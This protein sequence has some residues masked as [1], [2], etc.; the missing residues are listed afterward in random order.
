MRK[1]TSLENNS[2]TTARASTAR[3]AM[4]R[5]LACLTDVQKGNFSVCR[6]SDWTGLEGKV[7]DALNEII[8]ANERM[9]KELKRVSRMVGKQG[10]IGQRAA[11]SASGGAWQGMEES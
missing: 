8:T 5:I 7:A 11:F 2:P 3:Q 9:A 6:P 4:R 1:E 10:K